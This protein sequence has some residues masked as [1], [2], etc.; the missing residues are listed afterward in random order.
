MKKEI[1]QTFKIVSLGLIISASFAYANI[2]NIKPANPVAP[3]LPSTNVSIPIDVG[4]VSQLKKGSLGIGPLVVAGP[5]EMTGNI[6]INGPDPF[7]LP[8]PD[9]SND[10]YVTGKVGVGVSPTTVKFEVSGNAKISDVA[11][12]TAG[13]AKVCA[14]TN[15]VLL[16][17]PPTFTF[18]S[19]TFATPGTYSWSIPSNVTTATFKVWGGGG[20]GGAGSAS[21]LITGAGGAGG[22]GGAYYS[23]TIPVTEGETISIIVGSGGAAGSRVSQSI[24]NPGA[25]GTV[26]KVTRVSNG[27]IIA[28]GNGGGGGGGAGVPTYSGTTLTGLPAPASAGVG[29]SF[30]GL[31][32]GGTIFNSQSPAAGNMP[33][34]PVTSW[35]CGSNGA[36]SGGIAFFDTE[37]CMSPY[38]GSNVNIIVPDA[39]VA[40]SPGAGGGGGTGITYFLASGTSGKSSA[41]AN[42]RVT[43]SW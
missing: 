9:N 34:G 33:P 3:A 8:S 26:S 25:A 7:S 15:G 18:G 42:G 11:H 12:T 24:G 10:L 14:D 6:N 28:L 5:S 4:S 21:G 22:G 37:N 27:V 38:S 16:I 39:G 13:Q 29:G 23:T 19:I 36:S 35:V 30:S 1:I 43:I 20:G 17:C 2:W 31:G 40:S 32:G 41:G